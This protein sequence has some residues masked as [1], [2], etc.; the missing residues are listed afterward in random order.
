MSRKELGFE[1]EISVTPRVCGLQKSQSRLDE[2]EESVEKRR[3]RAEGKV[4]LRSV[5]GCGIQTFAKSAKDG[6]SGS[7]LVDCRPV[8]LPLREFSKNI[9]D[10]DKGIWL[11]HSRSQN[12][13]TL[14][15]SVVLLDT[16]AKPFKDRPTGYQRLPGLAVRVQCARQPPELLPNHCVDDR[17]VERLSASGRL[18]ASGS[19]HRPGQRIDIQ[20][21][22]SLRHQVYV[23]D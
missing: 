5:E 10:F 18:R 11:T 3:G 14:E 2:H 17:F 23:A 13:E 12:V 20:V 6:A 15:G 7:Q 8:R 21:V 19:L 22:H 9:P 4:K 1:L 16:G